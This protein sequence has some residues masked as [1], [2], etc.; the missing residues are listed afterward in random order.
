MPA[1]WFSGL[2][3]DVLDSDKC[4]TSL[5]GGANLGE[6]TDLMYF[7]QKLYK[8]L[9]VPAN[10]LNA[11]S[12]YEDSAQILREELKFARFLIR[13]QQKFANGLK[14]TFITHLKMKGLWY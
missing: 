11:E 10:R 6:L 12:R 2:R 4:V 5:P 8:A 9:K 14:N 3:M 13:L 1:A 7:V